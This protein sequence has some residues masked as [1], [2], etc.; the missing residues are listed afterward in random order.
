[1]A[2]VTRHLA[3][4]R[5]LLA[6]AAAWP[7]RYPGMLDSAVRGT[8][9]ARYDVLFAFPQGEL[10]LGRDGIVR[11]GERVLTRGFLDALDDAWREQRCA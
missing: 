4:R 6:L 8:A 3:G 5:D 7:E 2:H 1:V 11:D 9:Q 10:C